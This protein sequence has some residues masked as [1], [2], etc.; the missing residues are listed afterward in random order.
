MVIHELLDAGGAEDCG[1]L[2]MRG[3]WKAAPAGVMSGSSPLAEVVTRSTGTGAD[4]FSFA[5]VSA[6]PLTRSRSALEVG[7]ALEPPEFC[8]L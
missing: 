6:S 1:R 2:A 5:S 8:A 7:P 4:G 3:T